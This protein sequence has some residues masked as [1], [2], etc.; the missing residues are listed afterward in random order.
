MKPYGEIEETYTYLA[1]NL[2]RKGILY[3]HLVDHSSMGAP[4]V[5]AS[6]K[7]V[8]HENFRNT[9]ILAGGFSAE[10]AEEDLLHGSADLISFG[11]PFISNPDLVERMRN[12][13]PLNTAWDFQTFYTP[14]EKGYT[15]YPFHKG[16]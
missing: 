12:G 5:P 9:L 11:K 2:D 1:G 15:D 7:H 13:W 3:V 10:K 8:I 14:G 16:S 6:I 4:V